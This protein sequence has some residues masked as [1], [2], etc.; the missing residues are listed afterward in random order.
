MTRYQNESSS[1]FYRQKTKGYLSHQLWLAPHNSNGAT[2][3]K[4]FPDD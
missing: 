2:W 1:A 4:S 3:M